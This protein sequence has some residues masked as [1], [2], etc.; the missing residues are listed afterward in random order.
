MS[1]TMFGMGILVSPLARETRTE[2]KVTTWAT[3]N[4]KRK[5]W[6][7]LRVE[8]NR[9]GMYRM[10]NTLVMHPD[11]YEKLRAAAAPGGA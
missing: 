8:I 6:R 2:F 9:P 4:K 1:G 7:V 11:V 5:N 3:R 10:G